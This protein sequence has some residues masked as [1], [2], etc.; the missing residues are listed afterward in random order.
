MLVPLEAKKRMLHP[1]EL[2]FQ[3]T[4]NDLAWVWGW[5]W[6]DIELWSFARAMRA[7]N[8]CESV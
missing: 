7:P 6:G 4:M 1:L 2:E 3:A 5:G 8:H